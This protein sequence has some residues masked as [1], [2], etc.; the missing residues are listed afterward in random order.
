MAGIIA[1][2]RAS[3]RG[4]CGWEPLT[5]IV[6]ACLLPVWMCVQSYFHPQD[7]LALGLAFA[8]MA[9]A[10][11]RR[12]AAAGILCALAV[13]SQ[14]FALLVAA[15]LLLLAPASRRIVFAAAG[16]ATG[17][18]VV[19]PLAAITSGHALRAIALGTGDNPSEGGTVFWEFRLHGVL[20]V[21][22]SRVA[23]VAASLVLAWWVSRRLGDAALAPVTLLSVVAV[24]LGLRLVFEQ[25]LFSYYFMALAVSLVLLDVT[26]GYLRGSVLAWLA[27]L[28]LVICGYSVLP[29]TAVAWGSYS[30][31]DPVPLFIGALALVIVL[32][33][34]LRGGDRRTL[35]PWIGVAAVDLLILWPTA[36]P[37]THHRVVWFWQVI[38]VVPG[39]L[40]AAHPLL[41][42]LAT[43]MAGGPPDGGSDSLT[44]TSQDR[45]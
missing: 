10:L 9:C 32:V 6:V 35:W 26:D 42:K 11:R 5:L 33:Q 12:W 21:L 8:A 24:S 19:I 30:H 2:L 45:S 17:A 29:F 4:R 44:L 36:N 16:L 28:T 3:G 38:L 13:L 27:A 7:L 15:P 25:N 20:V 34:V 22:L 39:L 18:L 40:L 23:P 14:Q 31:V 41:S 43:P 1:W 37:L